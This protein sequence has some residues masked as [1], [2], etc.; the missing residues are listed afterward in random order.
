MEAEEEQ[1]M[2]HLLTL[3][4]RMMQKHLMKQQTRE[5]WAL[6]FKKTLKDYNL[7]SGGWQ[8][9]ERDKPIDDQEICK[10]EERDKP[11]DDLYMGGFPGG[12][13]PVGFNV[14]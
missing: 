2:Q 1:L 11:I 4:L 9:E 3:S 8:I 12:G 7:V 13:A 10:I 6:Q 5:F 14:G